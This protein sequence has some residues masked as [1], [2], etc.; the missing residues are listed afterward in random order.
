MASSR[1]IGSVSEAFGD[2]ASHLS[3]DLYRAR[4]ACCGVSDLTKVSDQ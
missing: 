3:C 2:F 4:L 1:K